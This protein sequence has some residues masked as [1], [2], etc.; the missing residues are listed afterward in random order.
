MGHYLFNNTIATVLGL[1]NLSGRNIS[2]EYFHPELNE[3]TS[4][5]AAPSTRYL[6]KGD[7]IKLSNLSLSYEIGN[8]GRA[9]KNMNISISGQ[10]LLVFT[11]YRG[12]DPEVN[13]S[14]DIDGIPS[15]G[16]EYIPYPSARTFL[17]GLNFT[18]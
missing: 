8:L 2:S 13:T 17:L 12:F 6:E 3:S 16:I 1:N 5:S 18:L 11:K 10:N 4:N 7:Y 9:F 15:L 14:G